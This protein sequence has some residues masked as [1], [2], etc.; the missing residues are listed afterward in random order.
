[1]KITKAQLKKIIKEELSKAMSYREKI[2]AEEKKMAAYLIK[3]GDYKANRN[4][5]VNVFTG[6][7]QG[8]R[9]SLKNSGGF[10]ELAVDAYINK[11]DNQIR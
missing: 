8:A 6:T 10:E 5:T 11:L 1:M 7:T 2:A 3:N 9:D 4:G